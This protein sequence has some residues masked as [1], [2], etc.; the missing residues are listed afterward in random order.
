M[1]EE[2]VEV[3]G[4]GELDGAMLDDLFNPLL[5]AKRAFDK[6][7]RDHSGS[8]DIREL[9]RALLLNGTFMRKNQLR[10]LMRKYDKDGS[11]TLS[12]NEFIRLPGVLPPE[13]G[14]VLADDDDG[15][16]DN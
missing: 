11:G 5:E 7:D 12:F 15:D 1:E 8:L 3:H 13:F 4:A 9:N 6:F 2:D 16:D 10:R 14:G